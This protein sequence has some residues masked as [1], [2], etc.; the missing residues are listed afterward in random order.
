MNTLGNALHCPYTPFSHPVH[1]L[2]RVSVE[3][4]VAAGLWWVGVMTGGVTH[5]DLAG[6]RHTA[7]KSVLRPVHRS[8]AANKS[9]AR[10]GWKSTSS[11][12]ASRIARRSKPTD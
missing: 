6:E 1:N 11:I 4:D 7:Y 9:S 10:T 8:T 12:P 5:S 2:A 3:S